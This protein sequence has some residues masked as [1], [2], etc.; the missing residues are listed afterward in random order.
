MFI[1]VFRRTAEIRWSTMLLE[2][3]A[4][5]N[6]KERPIISNWEYGDITTLILYD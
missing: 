2:L 3:A 1:V 4:R 5:K 6:E